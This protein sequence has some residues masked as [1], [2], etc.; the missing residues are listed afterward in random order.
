M[1]RLDVVDG[2]INGYSLWNVTTHWCQAHDLTE[3]WSKPQVTKNQVIHE[4]IYH[5]LKLCQSAKCWCYKTKIHT[6]LQQ[7]EVT[8]SWEQ[9]N[10]SCLFSSEHVFRRCSLF[11]HCVACCGPHIE[12]FEK[13]WGASI[14]AS[15]LL[16]DLCCHSPVNGRKKGGERRKTGLT[17][18]ASTS[19][20][21]RQTELICNYERRSPEKERQNNDTIFHPRSNRIRLLVI[22]QWNAVRHLSWTVSNSARQAYMTQPECRPVH[23][24]NVNSKSCTTLPCLYMCVCNFT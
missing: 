18:A 21:S 8:E 23:F 4:F 20:E 11:T 1:Q 15:Y 5:H 3:L 2:P 6:Q 19:S 13:L 14:L 17:Q 9:R 22:V 7:S 10:Q 24:S 16:P 12:V